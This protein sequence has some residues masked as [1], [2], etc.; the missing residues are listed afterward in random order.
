[1]GFT[2]TRPLATGLGVRPRPVIQDVASRMMVPGEYLV[3]RVGEGE[4]V[5]QWH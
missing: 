2:L 4:G 5:R 1:M 3:A